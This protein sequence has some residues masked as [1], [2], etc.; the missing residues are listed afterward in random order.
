[1]RSNVRKMSSLEH[2]YIKTK[3]DVTLAS[4]ISDVILG[5]YLSVLGDDIFRTLERI[6]SKQPWLKQKTGD[7]SKHLNITFSYEHCTVR[8]IELWNRKTTF[9]QFYVNQAWFQSK[10]LYQLPKKNLRRVCLMYTAE[11]QSFTVISR[12]QWNRQTKL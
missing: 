11:L 3:Y 12:K 1:M 2:R 4:I 8:H 6:K 5:F 9:E 7:P 10:Y